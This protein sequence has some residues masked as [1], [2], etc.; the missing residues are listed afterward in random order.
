MAIEP[1]RTRQLSL[2]ADFT[3]LTENVPTGKSVVLDTGDLRR[4]YN[5]GDRISELRIAQD[6]FFRLL[7]KLGKKSTDDPEFKFVERRNS[8]HKRY[9]YVVK[10]GPNEGALAAD[11][12]L[13]ALAVD[14]TLWVQMATDFLSSG[15][16]GSRRGQ[17]TNKI[18]VGST[19]TAP[20]FYV[21]G[22]VIKINTN[23]DVDT[24]T[25]KSYILG[26]I[27]TVN[28]T[29]EFANLELIITKDYTGS[30][31]ELTSFT[32]TLTPI[33][34]TWDRGIATGATPLEVA[35]SYVVGSAFGRGT[36]YPETW[37]D[38][39]FS[40]DYGYTQIFKTSLIMDRTTQA[41]LLKY[42]GNEWMRNWTEKL[43]QH[44]WDIETAFLFGA[45]HKDTDN[46]YYSEGA[47]DYALTY[48]NV[49]SLTLASKDHDEFV[50]DM[51]EYIDPRYNN[52]R[53][54][55]FYVQTQVWNWLHKLGGYFGN[56]VNIDSTT[57]RADMTVIA[58][59]NYK[60]V[61][62]SRIQLGTGETMNVV[63]NIHLDGSPVKMLGINHSNAKMRPLVGNG[64]NRD[65]HVRV[66]PETG[67][68]ADVSYCLTEA[69]LEMSTPE[70]HSVWL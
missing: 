66:L 62:M 16:I 1:L 6:P 52:D 41:T 19:G 11:E 59:G 9:G 5:F 65:T 68:D 29:G 44:K 56:N 30:N 40:T 28:L 55:V 21:P 25:N 67:V 69:G 64:L 45:L 20:N 8:F 39:P 37:V 33:V 23:D 22:L 13:A 70:G 36:E 42:E 50:D 57:F 14:D 43:I 32:A 3:G 18:D 51:S 7:S 47:V 17:V 34:T 10:Q 54:I 63:K 48:G 4:R 24:W 49:F 38:Q 53:A 31:T 27:K 26:R 15:L 2:A 60:G 12:T 46:V 35:R 58:K 61:P